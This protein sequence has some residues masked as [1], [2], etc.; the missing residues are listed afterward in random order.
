MTA[1]EADARPGRLARLWGA[2]LWAH[3]VVLGAVLVLGFALTRPG[4]AYTSDE[5]AAILQ[6]RL[7]DQTGDWYYRYPL[8]SIDPEDAARPFVRADQGEK[9]VAPYAKHPLYPLLLVA[10]DRVGGSTAMGLLSVAGTLGAAG[11]A[12]LL[13]RRFGRGLERPVLWVVGV[14]SPLLF[15]SWLVL[16]HT[17]GAAAVGAAGVAAVIAFERRGPARVLALVA[18]GVGVAAATAVRT[19][20]A[21]VVAGLLVGGAI[22]VWRDRSR[23]PTAAWVAVAAVGG[24]GVTLLAERAFFRSLLGAVTPGVA[25]A[26]PASWL[27]GRS[28]SFVATWLDPSYNG[29]AVG[30]AALSLAALALAVG[31]IAARLKGRNTVAIVALTVATGC[32]AVRVAA[33]TPGAIPGLVLA[34]PIGWVG[35]WLV[36][37]TLVATPTRAF[38]ATT[39]AVMVAAILLTQY[40]RG[41]GVEWGGRYFAVALP[42]IAPV[43]VAAIANRAR[44][45]GFDAPL[46]KVGLAVGVVVTLL[47]G[48]A[49]VQAY[50][51]VHG[52][53]DD[54]LAV[55]RVAGEEAGTSGGL[56]RPVVLSWNRLLPQIAYRDFDRYEWVVPDRDGLARYADRLAGLGVDRLVLVTPD[57]T[58]DLPELPGWRVVETPSGSTSLEV[59]VLERT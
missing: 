42:L 30:D 34:F 13:A 10:A 9:G 59:L 37:R 35:L 41:G 15:D 58:V 32:Y 21:F 12:A 33:G 20:G 8:A 45:L 53:T 6:A 23:W 44:V 55:M 29:A 43:L 19:E 1:A 46:V 38:V 36:D 7:L 2:P 24:A 51:K 49:S 31:A 57:S 27:A 26:P 40:P 14:G 54:V 5:G 25:D 3:V 17:L 39:G 56:D 28:E 11:C 16:A 4:V 48:V 18:V 47:L 50:R 52:A 22:A